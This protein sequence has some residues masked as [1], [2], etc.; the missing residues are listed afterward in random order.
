ML[1]NESLNKKNTILQDVKDGEDV[2]LTLKI[3]DL[4]TTIKVGLKESSFDVVDE[5]ES[6]SVSSETAVFLFTQLFARGTVSI[7]GRI[8]FNYQ[9]AHR[10]FLFFFH[11]LC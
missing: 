11:P 9:Q 1:F 8:T 7:N 10:F 3:S 6:I 5:A 2:F 4:D